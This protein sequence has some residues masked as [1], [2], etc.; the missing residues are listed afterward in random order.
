[1]ISLLFN[2]QEIVHFAAE[3]I[4]F[5]FISTLASLCLQTTTMRI[6]LNIQAVRDTQLRSLSHCSKLWTI[7][8]LISIWP[9]NGLVVA[10]CLSAPFPVHTQHTKQT[11]K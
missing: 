7:C 5:L 9:Q 11:P 6:K 8:T 1:M 2:C 4:L 3:Q 10:F